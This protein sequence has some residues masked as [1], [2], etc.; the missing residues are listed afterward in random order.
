MH[1]IVHVLECLVEPVLVAYIAYEI[2]HELVFFPRIYLFHLELFEFVSGKD[3]KFF[4]FIIFHN[5][6]D[7]FFPEG[8]RSAR[9]KYNFVV[10]HDFSL[11][12]VLIKLNKL[13]PVNCTP[14]KENEID[15]FVK[16]HNSFNLL[17]YI[18][19]PSISSVKHFYYVPGQM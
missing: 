15:A 6:F 10:Q 3:D 9:D 5:G 12:K 7:E 11:I 1:Y 16:C 8:P 13:R 17:H 2:P 14:D 4:W 19:A 18:Y